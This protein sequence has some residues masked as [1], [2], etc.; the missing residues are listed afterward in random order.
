VPI[1]ETFL[2][3]SGIAR[4]VKGHH[5]FTCTHYIS[6]ASGMN[7]NCLCLPSCSWYSFTDPEGWKAE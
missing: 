1:H 3:R 7:H 6:S 4:I 5:S 2:R